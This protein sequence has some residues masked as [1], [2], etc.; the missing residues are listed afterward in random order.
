MAGESSYSWGI[1]WS[2]IALR[3]QIGSKTGPGF[4]SVSGDEVSSVCTPDSRDLAAGLITQ[5]ALPAD[6]LIM[7]VLYPDISYVPPLGGPT[8]IWSS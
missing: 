5:G 2:D 3:G 1:S 4:A 8:K 7:A 6:R